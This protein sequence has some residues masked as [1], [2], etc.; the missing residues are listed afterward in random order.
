[1]YKFPDCSPL[2]Y[3]SQGTTSG[4]SKRRPNIQINKYTNITYTED[5]HLKF[6][7]NNHLIDVIADGHDGYEIS[8]DVVK[9]IFANMHIYMKQNNN[10]I[11]NTLTQLLSTLQEV[12]ATKY[13]VNTMYPR[14]KGGTTLSIRVRNLKTNILT[15]A[16]LGDSK[17]L[18]LRKGI[19]DN[20]SVFFETEDDDLKN[21]SERSRI[22]SLCPEYQFMRMPGESIDRLRRYLMVTAAIGDQYYDDIVILPDGSRHTIIRR[23]FNFYHIQLEHEDLIIASSDGLYEDFIPSGQIGGSLETRIPHV[24]QVANSIASNI[25]TEYMKLPKMLMDEQLESMSAKTK[26]SMTSIDNERDNQCI[27]VQFVNL[28]PHRLVRSVSNA[29]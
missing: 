14:G 12:I 4:Y 1:M 16:N 25:T 13:P 7:C 29:F 10:H 20:Y 5:A 6:N 2:S 27:H 9:F 3:I 26:Y 19:D 23:T 8:S 17:T 18:V 28:N 21:Q 22:L 24:L 11:E 15:I